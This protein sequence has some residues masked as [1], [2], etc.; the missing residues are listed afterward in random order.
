MAF[1]VIFYTINKQHNSTGLPAGSGSSYSCVAKEPLS[2]MSPV[3]VLRMAGGAA[4]NPVAWNYAYISEFGRYYWISDW[5]NVG[6]NW[7]ASMQVDVL[8]S[9]RNNIMSYYAYVLRATQ[10]SD[11]E[12][13][14]K[15]FPATCERT[16]DIVNLVSPWEGIPEPVVDGS[17]KGFYSVGIA[18]AGAVNYYAML[19]PTL[20][21]LLGYLMSDA[22]AAAALG[23]WQIAMYPEAKIALNPYQ[24]IT[25]IK[26]IPFIGPYANGTT[27]SSVK[28]GPV[29]VQISC[30]TYVTQSARAILT[31][32]R[33]MSGH[34]HPEAS[35]RGNWLN[36]GPWTTYELYYPPFGLIALDPTVMAKASTLVILIVVDCRTGT[37]VLNAYAELPSGQSTEQVQIAQASGNVGIDIPISGLLTRQP[38]GMTVAMQSLSGAVGAAA[39]VATGNYAAAAA[40]VMNTANAV[41]GDAVSAA[42][43]HLS[44]V[45]SQGSAAALTGTPC[46][47]I[48]YA[49]IAED[50]NRDFGRPLCKAKNLADL[51]PGFVMCGNADLAISGT[52]AEQVQLNNLLN[53]GVMLA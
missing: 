43:P 27:V 26:Y 35:V 20:E 16:C 28:V 21:Y 11:P 38:G 30:R 2:I 32:S 8:A 3:I 45:G 13:P 25:S 12:I 53:G 51:S 29:D 37:A 6:P 4:G 41:L 7:E 46:I 50:L 33:S 31:A 40:N 47:N 24:Y 42:I 49:G 19:G 52:H 10:E 5:T 23:V 18:S 39:G 44:V 14:D 1:N 9:F 36:Q 34:R 22:Y 15:A 48:V 17:P